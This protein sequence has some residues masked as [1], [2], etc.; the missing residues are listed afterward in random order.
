LNSVHKPQVYYGWYILATAMFIAF[1]TTGARSSFGIFIIPLENEFGWNRTTV[2]LAA[3]LGFLVNGLTQ[4]FL[5]HLFDRLGGRKVILTGLVITGLATVALSL[6]FHFL[7]LIFVFGF[8]LSTAMSGPSTTNTMA[9]LS[10]WFHRKRATVLGLNVVGGSLGGLLLIPFGMYLLQATNWRVTW[11]ALGLIILVLAVPLALL[12]IRDDPAQQGLQPDGDQAPPEDTPKAVANRQRGVF[13]V[14]RWRQSFRSPPMWQLSAA[15]TVCGATTGI[16]STHFVPYAIGQGVSASTAATIF[17]VMMGLNV[18]GGL[19]AGVLADRFGRK[20]VLAAVYFLRGV[21]YVF[22]LLIPGT[23]G[24]WVFAAFAGFSWVASVP[25]TT[26]LTADVYG[27][28][29][30]ATI[31]GVS[32]LCHQV[33]SFVSI[34]FAG[35]LFDVTGSYTLPFAIAGFLLFPAALSAFTIQERKYSIR[36]QTATTMQ[37]AD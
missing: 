4:P 5:G 19:G 25:L 2:S 21:G 29:A 34:L 23:V 14:D 6:T 11:I 20:N 35:F 13:E 9:L 15:Y 8:V 32:F 27:L 17:G 28:R 37:A 31:S 22:L 36:Y 12:F 26:A 24:L 1:V 16:I 30:L 18:L 7:F 3:A 10:K 33:G